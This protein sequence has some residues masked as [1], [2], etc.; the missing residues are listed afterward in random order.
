ML[1]RTFI[2]DFLPRTRLP[3]RRVNLS[4]NFRHVPKFLHISFFLRMIFVNWGRYTAKE[5]NGVLSMFPCTHGYSVA[6]H[7]YVIKSSKVEKVKRSLY[8]PW[9]LLALREVEASTFS[10]IRLIDGGKA[11][12]PTRRS[13]FTPRKIRHDWAIGTHAA[14]WGASVPA[15][16][17]KFSMLFLS[18][19]WK[20]LREYLKLFH[21]L[22]FT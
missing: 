2:K 17:T 11:V 16:L 21:D 6:K 18:L 15:I 14:C 10:D 12:S 4:R 9:R 13:L 19:S 1:Y 8:R 7:I 5:W 20:L 22:F 3:T